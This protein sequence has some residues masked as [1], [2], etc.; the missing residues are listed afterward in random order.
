MK[1]AKI[2]VKIGDKVYNI[3]QLIVVVCCMPNKKRIGLSD[4][5]MPAIIMK[6]SLLCEGIFLYSF[7]CRL[8]ERKIGI[9]TSSQKQ[10]L[11]NVA[12]NGVVS[13]RLIF[14]KIPVPPHNNANRNTRK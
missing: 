2:A 14:K 12:T 9:K 11:Q 3:C 5:K 13:K 1:Y 8:D 10:N 6:N 7:F 4:H